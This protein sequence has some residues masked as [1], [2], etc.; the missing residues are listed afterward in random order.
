[1]RK[2]LPPLLVSLLLG[3]SGAAVAHDNSGKGH[4]RANSQSNYA[5][6]LS[7]DTEEPPTTSNG[8][9]TA[10]VFVDDVLDRMRVQVDFSGLSAPTT[11]AH[12][13]CC[14]MDPQMGNV[15]VATAVPT[16]PDFPLDVMAGTFDRTF[17]LLSAS[18]YN[19]AFITA[20]GGT[21]ES[22]EA[23]LLAGLAAGTAYLNIH[24]TENPAGEIRGFLIAAPI[25]E[26]SHLGM[27]AMGLVLIGGARRWR[28]ILAA[29][30]QA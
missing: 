15:G 22:A 3:F 13:H 2:L 27:L 7:G 11:A 23:D 6:S 1:M 9:G 5:T 24:T 14:T 17:D 21:P 28:G 8:T 19:P 4:V 30:R 10:S 12:I 26:P 25:P 20:H 29:R 18:T 16:F